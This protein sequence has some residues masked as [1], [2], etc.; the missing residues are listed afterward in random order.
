MLG[1]HM[2]ID[3]KTGFIISIY[4]TE[5]ALKAHEQ[6]LETLKDAKTVK[7]NS[8]LFSADLILVMVYRLNFVHVLVCS[9]HSQLAYYLV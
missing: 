3:T 7:L 1:Y 9:L 5:D 8:S 2:Y 6:Y 4:N